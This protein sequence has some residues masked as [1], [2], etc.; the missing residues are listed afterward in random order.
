MKRTIYT[1]NSRIN[2]LLWPEWTVDAW[3]N[4]QKNCGMM[5]G[6]RDPEKGAFVNR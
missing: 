2:T 5:N 4:T 3:K 6:R 1:L